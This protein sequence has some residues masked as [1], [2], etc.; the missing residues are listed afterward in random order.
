MHDQPYIKFEVK[1]FQIKVI[2]CGWFMLGKL[3]D[4]CHIISFTNTTVFNAAQLCTAALHT[5]QGRGV[6]SSKVTSSWLKNNWGKFWSIL[7]VADRRNKC[8]LSQTVCSVSI[9]APSYKVVWGR[10]ANYPFIMS[11]AWAP[12]H[13][14]G[15]VDEV[16]WIISSICP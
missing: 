4:K 16:M 6:A 2:N 3:N 1:N 5:V 13:T 14:E 8:R 10:R 15:W 12:V 11:T 9:A 7:R